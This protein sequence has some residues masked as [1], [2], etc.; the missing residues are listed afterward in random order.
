MK[1]FILAAS[2]LAL[3]AALFSMGTAQAVCQ[4]IAIGEVCADGDP[5]SQTG[6]IYADGNEGNPDP[7]DGYIG[8]N[9][10]QGVVG[11]ASGSYDADRATDNDATDD[12]NVITPVPPTGP[13]AAPSQGPCTPSPGS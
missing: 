12:N 10:D 2:A 9:D 6:E 13:P 1:R 11:C 8:L 4:D 5:A 7:L 3:A